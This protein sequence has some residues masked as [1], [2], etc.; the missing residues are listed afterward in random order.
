VT[1]VLEG[2]AEPTTITFYAHPDLPLGESVR[3]RAEPDSAVLVGG[4]A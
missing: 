3:V 1:I 2:M 4:K